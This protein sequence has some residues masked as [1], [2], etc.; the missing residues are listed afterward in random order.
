MKQYPCQPINP[1]AD[2][3]PQQG[4]PPPR[5]VAFHPE[6][7]PVRKPTKEILVRSYLPQTTLQLL[8]GDKDIGQVIPE[9]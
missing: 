2:V 4:L 7:V 9:V 1:F 3:T 8:P 5:V 6:D